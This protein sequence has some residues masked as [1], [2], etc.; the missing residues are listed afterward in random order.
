MG[1]MKSVYDKLIAAFPSKCPNCGAG[2]CHQINW[3]QVNEVLDEISAIAEE[4]AK[5]KAVLTGQRRR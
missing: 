3:E 5:A 2:L 4:N 1:I